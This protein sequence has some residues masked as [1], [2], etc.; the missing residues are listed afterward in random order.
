MVM[1]C[2]LLGIIHFPSDICYQMEVW[3]FLEEMG[4]TRLP[5]EGS[6]DVSLMDCKFSEHHIFMNGLYIYI[7][8]N[9]YILY[10]MVVLRKSSIPTAYSLLVNDSS[11]FTTRFSSVIC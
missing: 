9:G 10:I 6:D 2:L 1:I 3:I 5:D 7:I 4:V 8:Y 11:N